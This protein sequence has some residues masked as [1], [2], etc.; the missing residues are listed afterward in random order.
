MSMSVP[1]SMPTIVFNMT[2]LCTSAN[3]P[4]DSRP[5]SEYAGNNIYPNSIVLGIKGYRREVSWPSPHKSGDVWFLRA[6]DLGVELVNSGSARFNTSMH[7]FEIH[8]ASNPPWIA[9]YSD[10]LEGKQ[11]VARTMVAGLNHTT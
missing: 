6:R 4:F 8:G 11:C 5:T 10:N 9:Y 3:A 7:G 2:F 1:R